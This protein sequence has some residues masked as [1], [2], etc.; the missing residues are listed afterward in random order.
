MTQMNTSP[1]QQTTKTPD[2]TDAVMQQVRQVAEAKYSRRLPVLAKRCG[3]NKLKLWRVLYD[4]QQVRLAELVTLCTALG[5][6]LS[7][8]LHSAGA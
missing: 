7:Q 2:A 3:W 5:L 1:S 8:L 4:G 6:P